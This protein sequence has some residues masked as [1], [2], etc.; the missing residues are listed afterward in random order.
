M[1]FLTNQ[2]PAAWQPYARSYIQ[3][4][5]LDKPTGFMLL[6]FPAWWA[7]M[8][9]TPEGDWPN[10]WIFMLFFIGAVA[11]RAAGC[12]V[13]D[14]I[15]RKLDA[16]V[17]RTRSRPVASGEI[18]PWQ[19]IAFAIG[20]CMVGLLVV[21]CM[22]RLAFV[23]AVASLPLIAL[24]PIMKRIT[25]WPQV[26]LGV[27]FN[28]GAM[29]GFAAVQTTLPVA[30]FILYAA[31]FF[32]TLSYDT[33]YAFQD[34]A[35]DEVAGIKSTAR[36]LGDD[37]KRTIIIWAG[38]SFVLLLAAGAAAHLSPLFYAGM[39]LALIYMAWILKNWRMEDSASSLA[40]FKANTTFGWIVLAAMVSGRV[41]V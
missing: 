39:L 14:V 17:E 34:K 24:Y 2:L 8:L 33:I 30:A 10:L 31:C 1:S 4:A 35:D 29:M 21:L 41:I 5:R 11:M 38:T 13:N 9:A 32:W 15:D 25:W 22:N 18:K 7:Q 36:V 3:L 23:L 16:Q 19:G 12:A 28:W 27:I 37:A 20:C 40:A 26:F 6:L